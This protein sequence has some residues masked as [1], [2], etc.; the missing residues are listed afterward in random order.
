[1]CIG[2]KGRLLHTGR[3]GLVPILSVLLI[4]SWFS[5][6]YCGWNNDISSLK[7]LTFMETVAMWWPGWIKNAS[8]TPF[9]LTSWFPGWFETSHYLI[10]PKPTIFSDYYKCSLLIL[11]R[12]VCLMGKIQKLTSLEASW[13]N[14]L[15]WTWGK[16]QTDCI[17]TICSVNNFQKRQDSRCTWKG[18][19]QNVMERACCIGQNGHT[20]QDTVQNQENSSTN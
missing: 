10:Q 3:K 1:M 2:G 5:E 19:L 15:E 12:F 4:V 16:P 8:Q 20:S 18:A 17:L 6:C 14:F 7:M 13:D 9:P 11:N